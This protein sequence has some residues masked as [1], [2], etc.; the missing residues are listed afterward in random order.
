MATVHVFTDTLIVYAHKSVSP[1]SAYLAAHRRAASEEGPASRRASVE[2]AAEVTLHA[3]THRD[4]VLLGTAKVVL[5]LS[6][7]VLTVDNE[8]LCIEGLWVKTWGY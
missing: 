4:G 2:T 6:T 8:L 5:P 3:V 1:L 7:R